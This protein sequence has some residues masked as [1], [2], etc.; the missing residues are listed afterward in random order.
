[1]GLCLGRREAAEHW[2]P[3]GAAGSTGACRRNQKR[4]LAEEPQ[5]LPPWGDF[6]SRRGL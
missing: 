1:M 2:V 6:G 5:V 3:A 4:S